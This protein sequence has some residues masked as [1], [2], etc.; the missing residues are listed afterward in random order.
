MQM[1]DLI[2][3]GRDRKT[4]ALSSHNDNP[5]SALQ[6]DIGR[7]FDDFWSRFERP[8]GLTDGFFGGATGN[9]AAATNYYST[10]GATLGTG[11]SAALIAN[12]EGTVL[13]ST[14]Y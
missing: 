12:R 7:V 5:V 10:P 14:N 11:V 8:F 2:P 9:I 13:S 4:T 1:K 6:R 3:W